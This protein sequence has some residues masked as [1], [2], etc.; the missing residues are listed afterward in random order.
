MLAISQAKSVLSSDPAWQGTPTSRAVSNGGKRASEQEIKGKR[1][2]KG[3]KRKSAATCNDVH[4]RKAGKRGKMARKSMKMARKKSPRYYEEDRV[5]VYVWLRNLIA[6][7]AKGEG[8][9]EGG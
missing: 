9:C 8:G 4:K 5:Y 6:S 2:R 7:R 3:R 1:V